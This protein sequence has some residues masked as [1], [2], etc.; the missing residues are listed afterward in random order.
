L[1][2]EDVIEAVPTTEARAKATYAPESDPI[3]NRILAVIAVLLVIAGLRASCAVTMPLAAAAVSS[4]QSG[5]SSRGS[6]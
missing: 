6:H 4:R 3:R 5:R 2:N 1:L